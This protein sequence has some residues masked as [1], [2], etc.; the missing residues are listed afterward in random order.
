M[1]TYFNIRYEFDKKQVHTAIEERLRQ[2]GAD[3]ICVAD[4][5]ILNIANRKPD[6]LQVVNGGMFSIC[7]SG[8]VPLYIQWLYDRRFEQYCGSQIFM[9]IIQSRRYRM[10]FMGTSQATLDGLK[11]NLTQWNPEVEAMTFY[12]LPFRSVEEFDYPAI[13]NMIE[14]DGAEIIWVAL[15]APKQEIFMN[16][17]KP[18]L[19]RGV[20]IAVGAAFKFFSGTEVKRAPEWMIKARLEFLYRIFSEPKKQLKRCAWIVITLPRILFIEWKRKQNK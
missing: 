5:V 14:T 1:E 4:G 13:A 19:Q 2:E 6:Y 17:L 15:G 9:D 3:Y 16:R 20:M 7:D 12:E 18:H 10:I 11:E 8:Y